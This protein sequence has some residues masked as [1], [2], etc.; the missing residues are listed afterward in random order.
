MNTT[1]GDGDPFSM[2]M[3]HQQH[4]QQ[5]YNNNNNNN[6]PDYYAGNNN[7]SMLTKLS[8]MLEKKG[9]SQDINLIGKSRFEKNKEYW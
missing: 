9:R 3:D 5:P 8:H 6:T 2:M 1:L 7:N 4:S